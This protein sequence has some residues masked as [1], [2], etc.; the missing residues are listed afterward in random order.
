MYSTF[1]EK[2]VRKYVKVIKTFN[3]NIVVIEFL[4]LLFSY[5]IYTGSR[6]FKKPVQI[7]PWPSLVKGIALILR[8]W[9]Y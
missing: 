6:G 3:L 5:S 1:K 4:N 7:R 8:A 2:C 9:N